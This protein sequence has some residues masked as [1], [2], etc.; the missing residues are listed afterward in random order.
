M[1]MDEHQAYEDSSLIHVIEGVS[2]ELELV[3][4]MLAEKVPE[5]SV[6]EFPGDGDQ[7]EGIYVEL[8]R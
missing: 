1:M 3:G 8:A 2:R 7:E 4:S 6:E 5:P